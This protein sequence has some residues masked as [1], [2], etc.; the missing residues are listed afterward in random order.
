MIST[1]LFPLLLLLQTRGPEAT[2]P[3]K[4][5]VLKAARLFDGKSDALHPER[6][7]DRRGQGHQGR[8]RRA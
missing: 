6:D 7:G 8:R 4:P 3:P 2:A 1:S 5:I